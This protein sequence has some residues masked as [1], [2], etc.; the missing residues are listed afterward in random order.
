MPG[1]Q[2]CLRGNENSQ[3]LLLLQQNY[4]RYLCYI[5]WCS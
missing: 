2:V 3:K 1:Q 4:Y 5:T